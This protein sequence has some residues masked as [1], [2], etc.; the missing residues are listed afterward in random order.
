MN[1]MAGVDIALST[2]RSMGDPRALEPYRVFG[3]LAF[4][5]DVLA[6]KRNRELMQKQEAEREKLA[7]ENK[8]EKSANQVRSLTMKSFD[9]SMALAR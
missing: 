7:M 2:N 3:A 4:S 1:A 9:D 6:G 5:F 8:A